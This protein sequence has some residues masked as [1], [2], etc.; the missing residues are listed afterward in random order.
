MC[1]T[2]CHRHRGRLYFNHEDCA[3]YGCP[4]A[5]EAGRTCDGCRHRQGAYCGLT[6]EPLPAGG[7]CHHNVELISGPQRIT[8]AMIEM[9]LPGANENVCDVLDGFDVPY[10]VDADGAV[11]I[12]PDEVPGL[13]VV[14][15]LGTEA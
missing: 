7:C 3:D 4:L 8:R 13:P 15:G 10:Q 12:D 1:V 5:E 2:L 11:W 9:L 14:Y 6:R